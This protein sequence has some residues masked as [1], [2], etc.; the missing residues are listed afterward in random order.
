MG[1]GFG[2]SVVLLAAGAILR[3]AV[4][5]STH[6]FNLHTIGVILMIAGGVGLVLSFLWLGV[7]SDHTRRT[8]GEGPRGYA[9]PPE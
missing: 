6:G 9:G 5:V 8:P 1:F 3:F 7:W 2:T 4:S